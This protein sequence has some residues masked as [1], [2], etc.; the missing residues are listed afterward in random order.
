MTQKERLIKMITEST[1][2]VYKGDVIER[3][4]RNRQ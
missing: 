1:G 4:E 3:D 2:V